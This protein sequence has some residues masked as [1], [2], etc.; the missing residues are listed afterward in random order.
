M[1]QAGQRFDTGLKYVDS[2]GVSHV[3][4]RKILALNSLPNAGAKNFPHAEALS[5]S[6]YA[7]VSFSVSN[8]TTIK[9]EQSAGISI[10]INATNV[11]I[12][13]AAD[14]TAYVNGL[15]IL[16]FCL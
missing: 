6:R 16:D 10:D 2:S 14:L 4:Y 7:K 15:I 12:T 11:A 3:I 5:A 9:T 13:T 8:G 1:I